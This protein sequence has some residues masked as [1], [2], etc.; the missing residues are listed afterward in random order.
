MLVL[1]VRPNQQIILG[2]ELVVVKYLEP[3]KTAD[4]SVRLGFSAPKGMS[5]HREKIF[6]LIKEHKEYDG[7]KRTISNGGIILDD[8]NFNR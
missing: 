2:D 4:F 5:I 3:S 1:T 6:R 7:K 8:E